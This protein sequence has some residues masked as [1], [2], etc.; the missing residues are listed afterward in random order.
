[1]RKYLLLLILPLAAC[2]TMPSAQPGKKAAVYDPKPVSTETGIASWYGGRWIG[3]LTAN[4]ERYKAN[5]MTAAH[6]KLPF[7]TKVRVVDLKTNKSVI[8]RINNRG[9]FKKGRIVDLSVAA[10]RQ[11]GTYDRGLAKVRVEVLREIPVLDKP[12]IRNKPTATE[13]RKIASASNSA[14]R[15]NPRPS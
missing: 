8:V 12:N 11:L 6:K 7:N 13:P 10:A 1:M 5:D 2:S 15:R 4:G 9:P 3:R 14:P